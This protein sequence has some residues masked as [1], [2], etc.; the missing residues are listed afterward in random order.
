MYSKYLCYLAS[1]LIMLSCQKPHRTELR[2]FGADNSD[3]AKVLELEEK[4]PYMRLITDKAVHLPIREKGS[5][6]AQDGPTTEELTIKVHYIPLETAED[7][8]VGGRIHK[9]ETDDSSIFIFDEDNN[10][11]LRF[12]QKDGSFM[13]KYGNSGRGPGE[14]VEIADMSLNRQKKEVCLIDFPGCKFLYYDYDGRLLREEPLYYFYGDQEF[15]GEYV[16]QNTDRNGND[17][18]PSVNNKRLV[19]AKQSD[20]SPVY[21]AFPFPE[22]A[23]K[24]FGQNVKHPFITCNEEVYYNHLLS[25]TIWQIMPDG[26]CEAKYVFKFP[27]RDNLFDENDFRNMSG[28]IYAAKTKEAKCFYRDN[29][30]IT[31]DFVYAG[32][33]NGEY[34]LYCIPTGH[35]RYGMLTQQGFGNYQFMDN[36]LTLDGKSFVK[37]L[38]PFDILNFVNS[39]MGSQG[40]DYFWNHTLNEEERCLLQT[41]TPEDNPVLM[42]I[43]IEP[44]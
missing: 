28:D 30:R 27:G 15:V 31:K 14:Y 8:L 1:C 37:V 2:P 36:L 19:L 29:I 3:S 6:N 25:D 16:V 11:A 9:L 44:F 13:N 35:C 42:V 17:M 20:Q 39:M 23:G 26:T 4:Y 41:M 5:N 12:S 40:K 22:N 32:V 33:Q 21:V 7:C 10:Q 24:S 43:D 18:A 34:M 38:Q